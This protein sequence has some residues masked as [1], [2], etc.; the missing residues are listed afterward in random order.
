MKYTSQQRND[1]S[2]VK[3]N[4]EHQTLVSFPLLTISIIVQNV[5]HI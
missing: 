2:Y 3:N 1:T 5:L 4:I